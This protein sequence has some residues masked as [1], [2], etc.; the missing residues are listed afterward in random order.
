[1]KTAFGW[2]I[3]GAGRIAARF[4]T[5]LK[6][7]GQAAHV[8]ARLAAVGS[9]SR[10]RADAFA[11][12]YGFARAYGSYAELVNDPEVDIVYVA[13]PHPFH[14]EHTLLCLGHHKAVLCEKPMGI[15][16]QQ[17]K[18]MA[19]CARQNKAFLMEAMWSRFNPVMAQVR[20]WLA[21]HKIGD[22]RMVTADFGF[23]SGWDPEGR[24]L[25]PSLAGGAL[26][27]VG[28]YV[29][30]LALMILGDKPGSIQVAAHIGETGVDEQTAMILKY[31]SG[32]LAM[33][34][35][36]VRTNTPQEARIDGAI[37]SIHIPAFWHATS[38]TLCVNGQPPVEI[39]SAEAGE[40]GYHWEAAEA[41]ACLQ[42][43]QIESETIPLSESIAIA[44]ILEEAR[45]QIGLR[46]PME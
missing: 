29:V 22:V 19:T 39:T 9:R 21:E 45:R 2:G 4:A 46:Y 44:Q 32:Q 12:E 40:P 26:L 10:D 28:V 38:A 6:K 30:A 1:M 42:A 11:A 43:G 15:N 25:N 24:L 37:G 35:C 34:S 7:L 27:D 14:L 20:R 18:D 33:L 23:R 41:M 8:Q 16:A 13:T 36:A 17:V 3:L 31:G 5:D